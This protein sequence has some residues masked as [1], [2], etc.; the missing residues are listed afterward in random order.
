MR[1]KRRSFEV[2]NVAFLD[3]VSCA[4]GAVVLLVLVSHHEPPAGIDPEKSALEAQVAGARQSAAVLA[5]EFAAMKEDGVGLDTVRVALEKRL[6]QLAARL[7]AA[8]AAATLAAAR[9]EA[10]KLVG[11]SLRKERGPL[12]AQRPDNTAGGIPVDSE[13]VVFIID[14]SGSMLEIW[15]RVVQ[16]V[17]EVLAIHPKVT[18]FQIINDMG[19]HLFEATRGQWLPDTPKLRQGAVRMMRGGWVKL[20]N[21][22]P[23]EGLEVAL[24]LY[25]QRDESVSVYIFGDDYTGGSFDPVIDTLVNLNTNPTSGGYRARVHGIGFHSQSRHTSLFSVLMREVARR[26]GGAFLGLSR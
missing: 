24:R 21:S 18:G 19:V 2:F 11:A 3:V 10:L 12:L 7:G 22:S 25:A 16:V 14:N 9:V 20:S 15:D 4:F 13:Y 23:V 5:R 1:V 8:D 6:I 26:N 17:E